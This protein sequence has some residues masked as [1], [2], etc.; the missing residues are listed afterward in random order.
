M[1]N[2]VFKLNLSRVK[3]KFKNSQGQSKIKSAK[4]NKAHFDQ[5]ISVIVDLLHL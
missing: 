2:W 4:I 3:L 5:S 1:L